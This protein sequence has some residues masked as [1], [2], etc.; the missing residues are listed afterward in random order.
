LIADESM[1]GLSHSEIE[2]IVALLIR[3]NEGG[4][5]IILIEHIMRAVLSFSQRLVVLVSGKKIADGKPDDVIKDQEVVGAY[6]GA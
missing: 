2:D 4:I 6:L 5:T 3:L 1:A